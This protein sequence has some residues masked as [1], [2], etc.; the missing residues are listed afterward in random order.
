VDLV[1]VVLGEGI[2]FFAGLKKIPVE[3]DTPSVVEAKGVT[4]LHYQVRR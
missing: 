3:L 4:H 2:P 1:P